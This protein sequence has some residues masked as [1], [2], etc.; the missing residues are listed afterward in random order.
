MQIFN[1]NTLRVKSYQNTARYKAKN[2]ASPN[3]RST[4]PSKM[5]DFGEK[6]GRAA[7]GCKGK[8]GFSHAIVSSKQHHLRYGEIGSIL[9]VYHTDITW[10]K[11]R[12][13]LGRKNARMSVSM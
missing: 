11:R 1:T 3:A 7:S 12:V 2:V 10:P 8:A 6:T 9:S 13:F 4:G 5:A